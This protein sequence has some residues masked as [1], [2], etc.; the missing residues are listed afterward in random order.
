MSG[1]EIKQELNITFNLSWL[2]GLLIV[3]YLF[4]VARDAQYILNTILGFLG[5]NLSS[6]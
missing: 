3:I 4:S 1:D 6:V 2:F 5:F